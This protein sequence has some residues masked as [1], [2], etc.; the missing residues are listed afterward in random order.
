[1]RIIPCD[2]GWGRIRTFEGAGPTD[3]QSVPFDRFGTHPCARWRYH[4]ENAKDWQEGGFLKKKS[5]FGDLF[6]F[7]VSHLPQHPQR[8]P[9]IFCTPI[10]IRRIGQTTA[11]N[12][13]L[14]TPNA[15]NRNATPISTKYTGTILW[16]IQEHIEHEAVFS[17]IESGKE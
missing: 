16:H 9:I 7:F 12:E 14:S 2:G 3:L 17:D 11:T 13:A 10:K 4:I 5:P 15:C 8:D 6:Y 1:M